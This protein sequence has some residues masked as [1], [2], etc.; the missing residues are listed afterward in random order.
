MLN[1]DRR[2]VLRRQGNVQVL[3]I[4]RE[5]VDGP[6][7]AVT[8]AYLQRVQHYHWHQFVGDLHEVAH[9]REFGPDDLAI[10]PAIPPSTGASSD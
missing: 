2:G 10:P 7:E 1:V 9:E 3:G 5:V 6:R 8:V 4:V